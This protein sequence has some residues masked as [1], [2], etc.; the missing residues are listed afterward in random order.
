M[1]SKLDEALDEHVRRVVRDEFERNTVPPFVHQR[2]VEVVCGLPPRFYLALARKRAFP[3]A[4][5]GRL[6]VAPTR[7]VLAYVAGRMRH[8][9][10]VDGADVEAMALA[11]VGAR[12][13]R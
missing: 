11:R 5:L 1:A 3:N 4:K 2:S 6:V 12:R 8:A 7:E 10:I 9:P 13:V